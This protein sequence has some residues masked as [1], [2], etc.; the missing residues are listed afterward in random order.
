M[1]SSPTNNNNNNNNNNEARLSAQA[2]AAGFAQPLL[3]LSE[4]AAAASKLLL[5][6]WRM[7][8]IPCPITEY[9]LFARKPNE[10]FSVRLGVF[11]KEDQPAGEDGLLPRDNLD[12]DDDN[13]VIGNRIAEKLLQGWT[14]LEDTCPKTRKCPLMRDPVSKRLWTPALGEYLDEEVD[15][16]KKKAPIPDGTPTSQEISSRLGEKL[17]LGWEML[18]ETCESGKCPLMRDGA[19]NRLWSAF[20]GD[21]VDAGGITPSLPVH[22]EKAKKLNH[23]TLRSVVGSKLESW[24]L[25]L[26]STSPADM[27]ACIKLLQGIRECLLTIEMC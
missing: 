3:S 15:N 6:G 24:T 10:L 26:A 18:E 13:D 11:V 16:K 5:S 12:D 22:D 4:T 21:Y 17:L 27:D 23:T 1:S 7:T 8:D 19:T 2:Q 9:P 14:L 25:Q 20:Y